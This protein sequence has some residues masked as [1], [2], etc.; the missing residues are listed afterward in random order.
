LAE[1]FVYGKIEGLIGTQADQSLLKSGV[2]EVEE[3]K[4][5]MRAYDNIDGLVE[6]DDDAFLVDDGDGGN[7]ALREHVYDVE[8]RSI[9]GG[10]GD[11]MVR[12]GVFR[13][14]IGRLCNIGTD[15]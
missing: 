9:E 3:E 4:K 12:I 2:G 14:T 10:G 8:Y 7:G 1:G 5:K 11:G 13:N 6:V 15:L